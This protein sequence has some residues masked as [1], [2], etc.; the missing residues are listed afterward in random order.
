MWQ[1]SK[2]PLVDQIINDFGEIA[3]KFKAKFLKKIVEKVLPDYK[4]RDKF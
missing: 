3:T 4:M 2:K 1:T